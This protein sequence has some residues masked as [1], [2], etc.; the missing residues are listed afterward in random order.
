MMSTKISCLFVLAIAYVCFYR[1]RTLYLFLSGLVYSL[2][3]EEKFK[4]VD[5]IQFFGAPKCKFFKEK[6]LKFWF[7]E[8]YPNTFF[9]LVKIYLVIQSK[10]TQDLCLCS[11]NFYE[12]LP[13]RRIQ[14]IKGK[15]SAT[16]G[17]LADFDY[18]S[19]QKNAT[20]NRF[21]KRRLFLAIFVFL[22][23]T[24]WHQ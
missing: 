6:S 21:W 18:F 5:S 10:Y 2:E 15:T 7:L 20:I 9:L 12:L 16:F 19:H 13:N 17:E 14:Q 23:C 22:Q 8:I 1:E 3:G 4:L 24:G 11:T